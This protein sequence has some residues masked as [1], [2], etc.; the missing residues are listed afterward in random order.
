MT[1]AKWLTVDEFALEAR[2]PSR[3]VLD[4]IQDGVVRAAHL[5]DRVGSARIPRAELDRLLT[6]SAP[7][8]GI[9]SVP[10]GRRGGAQ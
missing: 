2:C 10:T 9:R 1:T 6:L 8:R 4:W 7:P 5:P 3:L